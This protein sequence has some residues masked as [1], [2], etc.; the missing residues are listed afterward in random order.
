MISVVAPLV[1]TYRL[2]S[3]QSFDS[4]PELHMEVSGSLETWYRDYYDHPV[5]HYFLY[6]VVWNS[7]NASSCFV[8]VN[9][10]IRKG[11]YIIESGLIPIGNLSKGEVQNVTKMFELGDGY[12]EANLAL[13]T[14]SKVWDTFKDNFAISFPR[15]GFGDFVR[16]YV[17]PRDPII[18]SVLNNVGRDVDSLYGWV[19]DNI[20]YVNDSDAHG[21]RDYWQLPYETLNLTTGD[22]EDQAFLL[23]SLIRAS[24]VSAEDVFMAIGTVDE[25]GHAWV[26]IKA[27]SGWRVLEPTAKGIIERFLVDLVE[28]FSLTDRKYYCTSNDLYFEEINHS[29]NLPCV[30][31]SF[32]GWWI[33]NYRLQGSRVTVEIGC[34]VT[35]KINVTNSGY[36][37]FIGLVKIEAKKDI[38]WGM[39]LVFA[40]EIYSISLYPGESL[41]LGLT[42]IADEV[43]E[44]AAWK[45][46]HYYYKVYTCFACIYDPTNANTRECLFVVPKSFNT[47][48]NKDGIINILDIA[49]VAKAFG[50]KPGDLNWNPVADLNK[51]NVIN[52]ID[53]A[54]VARDYGKTT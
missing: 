36:Y 48:L 40:S 39:D 30:F 26:V 50:T 16:F 18:Q 53:V 1:Q 33:D 3:Q 29:N 23:C 31:Q 19:G 5:A 28:F 51:D 44:D 35:L 7:G 42:F 9:F 34:Q 24:G 54:T 15:S 41:Q 12:Y 10:S 17:T 21:V 13:E 45:T 22:C 4:E 14:P 27:V 49:I 20:G 6:I 38:V 2:E 46:R 32:E 8:N 11:V 25:S 37:I 47:D 52:I 43:T